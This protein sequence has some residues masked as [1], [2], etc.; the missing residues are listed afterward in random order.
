MG[1]FTENEIKRYSIGSNTQGLQYN[2][3]GSLDIYIQRERPEDSI[4][5]NWLPSPKDDGFY[6]DLR[7]YNPDNSLQNG[8]WAPPAVKFVQ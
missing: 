3:D 8:T 6:L 7:L 5:S 4:L 1:R 2:P